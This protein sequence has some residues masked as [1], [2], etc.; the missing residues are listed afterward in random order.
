MS[1]LCRQAVCF[2]RAVT[3]LTGRYVCMSQ[4]CR[5][6]VCVMHAVTVLTGWYVTVYVPVVPT[7]RVCY[8]CCHSVNRTIRV[9][10]PNVR[11]GRVCY[12]CCHSVNRTIRVYVPNVS[13]GR[14]CYSFRH[15]VNRTIRVYVPVVLTGR[16]CYAWC[17]SVN[18]TIRDCVCR[19]I[20]VPA[21]L[22]G[23]YITA[24][25]FFFFL[26]SA[27]WRWRSTKSGW[28]AAAPTRRYV[29]G[30]SRRDRRCTCWK[31]TPRASG[32]WSSSRSTSS[33]PVPST[34]PSK[35]VT[36][37]FLFYSC[38]YFNRLSIFYLFIWHFILAG[39]WGHLT[40]ERQQQPQ[41]QRYPNPTG[42]CDALVLTYC[43]AF[44]AVLVGE[45]FVVSVV[46]ASPLFFFKLIVLLIVVVVVFRCPF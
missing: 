46:V 13:T 41:E 4:M 32:V 39:N 26:S 25:S 5:Q 14:V 43:C 38:F 6:A 29:S 2:M 40:W 23:R 27:C 45:G 44:C 22:T 20:F 8:A 35:S 34:P 36:C 42:V 24:C 16:E 37:F 3:V 7:G 33:F 28:Q 15:S 19:V 11:I 17:H 10:V 12:A 21:F 18:R 31:V 1:Q 9:Y 30:T